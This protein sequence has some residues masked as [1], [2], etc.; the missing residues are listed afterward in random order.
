VRILKH[1]ELTPTTSEGLWDALVG[2]F[3]I[4]PWGNVLRALRHESLRQAIAAFGRDRVGV[5][6]DG[7]G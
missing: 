6:V 5:S 7:P 3:G 2:A 4:V 1:V